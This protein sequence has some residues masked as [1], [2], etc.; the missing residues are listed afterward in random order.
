MAAPSLT[1]SV[2]FHRQRK[3]SCF[4][5]FKMARFALSVQIERKVDVRVLAATNADLSVQIAAGEFR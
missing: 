5:P 2:N 4:G 3:H 1:S